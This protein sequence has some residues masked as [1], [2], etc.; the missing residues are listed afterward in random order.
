MDKA[1]VHAVNTKVPAA[2]TTAQK[3]VWMDAYISAGEKYKIV[4]KTTAKSSKPQQQKA[5]LVK[6]NSAANQQL[7]R[8]PFKKKAVPTNWNYQKIVQRGLKKI[9]TMFFRLSPGGM[10]HQLRK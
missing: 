6:S 10:T 3:K 7:I 5:K 8:L 1:A 4:N 9:R 2:T